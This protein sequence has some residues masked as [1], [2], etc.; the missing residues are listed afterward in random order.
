MVQDEA[1]FGRIGEP[2]RCW[3]P[4]GIRPHTPKQAIR[5]AVYAFAAIAPHLGKLLALVLPSADTDMMNLF[6]Q[7]V[8]QEFADS[9]ILMQ[10]DQAGWHRSRA[11]HIPENIRLIFHPPYSPELNPVEH[12][13]DEL[14]EKF[15]LNRV[16]SS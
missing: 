12:L 1:R 14:R 16:F 7:Q 5:Q 9:F 8:A 6:L 15:F 11:L 10:V 2:R 4:A 13:W 3:A